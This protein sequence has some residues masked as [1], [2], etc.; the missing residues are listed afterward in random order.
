M[1]NSVEIFIQ[2]VVLCQVLLNPDLEWV[3]EHFLLPVSLPV[4]EAL[5]MMVLMLLED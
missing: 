2:K 4:L 1:N 3:V 5:T